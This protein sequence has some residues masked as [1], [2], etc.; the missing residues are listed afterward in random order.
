MEQTNWNKQQTNWNKLVG[1]KYNWNKL[2]GTNNKLIGNKEKAT[3]IFVS[4]L[5]IIPGHLP[6]TEALDGLC[7]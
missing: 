1:K 4:A 3:E 5:D 6:I 7:V 2:I